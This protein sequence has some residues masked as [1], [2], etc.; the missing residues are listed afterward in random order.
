MKHKSKSKLFSAAGPLKSVATDI[1]R[2]LLETLSCNQPEDVVNLCQSKLTCNV[3]M[4]K[5]SSM[6]P[7]TIF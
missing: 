2:L 5:I 3:F 6:H 1:L 4:A 7:E